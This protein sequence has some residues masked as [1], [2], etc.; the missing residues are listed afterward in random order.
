MKHKWDKHLRC[1][2]FDVGT[3]KWLLLTS[4]DGDNAFS[5]ILVGDLD[6]STAVAGHPAQVTIHGGLCRKEL[7]QM[8]KWGGK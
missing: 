3:T 2:K 4:D 5:V 6:L 7:A 1:V 8:R